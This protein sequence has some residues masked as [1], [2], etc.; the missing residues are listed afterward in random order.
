MHSVQRPMRMFCC[1]ILFSVFPVPLRVVLQR[2]GQSTTNPPWIG[3]DQCNINSRTILSRITDCP[4][5]DKNSTQLLLVLSGDLALDL[6]VICCCQAINIGL[7]AEFLSTLRNHGHNS[8]LFIDNCGILRT[9]VNS[10]YRGRILNNL[11]FEI[12]VNY[13]K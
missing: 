4:E 3:R 12:A 13:R 11:D 2:V 10:V 8:L 9:F 6:F 5:Q 7:T 1:V